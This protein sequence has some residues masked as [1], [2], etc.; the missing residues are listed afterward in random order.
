[1]KHLLRFVT[2]LIAA[3]LLVSGAASAQTA[4][5]S[6][7]LSTAITGTTD[8]Q[9]VITST[10][11][12]TATTTGVQA[13]ALI[14]RE[15]V[16]VRTVNTTTKVIGITRGQLSTR[17]MTHISGATVW[18]LPAN[19]N[20]AINYVPSGQ[21][22]RTALSAVPV[23]VQG[24]VGLTSEVGGLW[25]CLGVTTAGQ[26]VETNGNDGLYVFGSTVASATSVTPTGNYFKMS[27]TVNPVSTI[28]LPAG[29]SAGFCLSIEPTGAWV[30]DTGGNIL[31]AS[32]AV[33]GK[34]MTMCWNG[35]KW[36]PSY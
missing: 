8:Q 15:I 19:I 5:T 25:D 14:D 23:V 20:A 6:T 32:T 16:S 17:A 33:T 18:Y 9:M 10:T 3:L 34:V 30:T 29:T 2:A 1:M 21:C 13:Y 24:G 11:G 26:W 22:T 36:A 27:G 7:T 4:L 35:A 12:W 31:I 28:V